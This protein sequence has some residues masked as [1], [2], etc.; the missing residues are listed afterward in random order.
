MYDCTSNQFNTGLMYEYD[1]IIRI[2]TSHDLLVLIWLL[3]G[4]F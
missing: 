1:Y 2:Y 3:K 4:L